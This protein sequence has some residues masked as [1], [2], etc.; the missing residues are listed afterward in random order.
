[1]ARAAA[2]EKFLAAFEID[3]K[4]AHTV[5]R[6]RPMRERRAVCR[7][8]FRT[9]LARNRPRKQR[10][11]PFRRTIDKPIDRGLRLRRDLPKL[12]VS[13]VRA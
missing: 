12:T 5:S 2:T 3:G 6:R 10:N 13:K 4:P 9:R 11:M 7:D 8:V 1:M